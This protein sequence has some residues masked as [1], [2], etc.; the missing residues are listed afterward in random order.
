[1]RADARQALSQPSKELPAKDSASSQPVPLQ[2]AEPA[3]SSENV[4][5]CEQMDVLP[6]PDGRVKIEFY[7][8]GHR[9]A[10]IQ[11][12]LPVDG[13]T[14]ILNDIDVNLAAAGKYSGKFEITWKASS[15]TNS[16]GVP[17]KNITNVRLL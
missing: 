12:V 16:K 7:Q 4:M 5:V 9:Y 1:M 14:K 3:Q 15:K 8:A 13:W 6:Q 10:D 17:Y 2:S 11:G